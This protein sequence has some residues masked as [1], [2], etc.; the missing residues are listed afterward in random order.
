M[1]LPLKTT[2]DDVKTLTAFLST[3]TMGCTVNEAKSIIDKK[4]LDK[5]KLTAMK[6]WGFITHDG[7]KL[8]NTPIGREYAKGDEN[9]KSK[10]LRN[11]ITKTEAYKAVIERVSHRKEESLTSVE[12]G[13]HWHEHFKSDASSNETSLN[14]Q[15][16]CFFQ[17][18]QG[19]KFGILKPG[20]KK[21]PTRFEFNLDEIS[22]YLSGNQEEGNDNDTESSTDNNKEANISK[23]TEDS[24][25]ESLS[26][27]LASKVSSAP[28]GIIINLNIQLNVPE[29]TDE[30]VYDKFFESMKKH[31]LS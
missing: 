9:V 12:V 30:K 3:K 8:K 15:T 1:A 28:N 17:L 20:R 4:Y 16:V 14:N 23:G 6:S 22:K 19:S 25:A 2:L 24:N 29:T 7:D 21:L 27:N 31:I 18:A 26:N 10:I 13:T 5:R 11:I